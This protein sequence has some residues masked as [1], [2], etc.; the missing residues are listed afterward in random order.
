MTMPIDDVPYPSP[1]DYHLP[2]SLATACELGHDLHY[3]KEFDPHNA[4]LTEQVLRHNF[5]L[6]VDPY[7]NGDFN[8]VDDCH[9]LGT[10][11]VHT[12]FGND[13]RAFSDPALD[14]VDDDGWESLKGS[15]DRTTNFSIK[16]KYPKV[17]SVFLISH[18]TSQETRST[19]Q[20]ANVCNCFTTR[21]TSKKNSDK[22]EK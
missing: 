11:E 2:E 7:S 22:I 12:L 16:A 4:F 19:V 9:F 3:L 14:S 13:D 1:Y 8:H 5:Y 15:K 18:C 6:R 20:P 21:R 17:K 10:F